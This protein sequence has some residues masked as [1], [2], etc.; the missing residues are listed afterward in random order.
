MYGH[1]IFQT[2]VATILM[3][4]V[5]VVA[6]YTVCML[7]LL[8]CWTGVKIKICSGEFDVHVT[9]HRDKFLIT[10][11]TRC[12][13]FSNLFLEGNYMFRTVPLSIIRSFS[14]YTQQ[15]YMSYR[16]VDSLRA[17]SGWNRVPSWS[18]TQAVSKPLWHIPLLCVQWKT[19]DD[20]Q[21]NCPKHVVS[22]QK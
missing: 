12:T 18:C 2:N 8:S 10:K 9:V 1:T 15:W 21:R 3:T 5:C 19:P 6:V 7:M 14:L 11:P 22:F 13:Y 17:G 20:R 4:S 16:I